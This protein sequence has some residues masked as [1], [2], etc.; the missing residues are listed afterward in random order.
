MVY[1]S[2]VSMMSE[3]HRSYTYIS[4]ANAGKPK[5]TPNEFYFPGVQEIT[6]NMIEIWGKVVR[7]KGINISMDRIYTNIPLAEKLLEMKIT[8]IGTLQHNRRGLPA[9][10]KTVEK[11][12]EQSYKMYYEEKKGKMT[13]HSYFVKTKSKG[14]KNILVQ[15]TTQPLL[16]T[17]KDDGK[18]KPAL[19]KL[20]DFTKGGTDIMDQRIG[21]YSLKTMSRKWSVVNFPYNLDTIR[22]NS[23]TLRA[24]NTGRGPRKVDSLDCGWNLAMAMIELHLEGRKQALGLTKKAKAKVDM[25][26]SIIQQKLTTPRKELLPST[27]EGAGKRCITKKTKDAMGKIKTQCQECGE[28]VC[29]KHFLLFCVKCYNKSGVEESEEEMEDE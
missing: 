24:L 11:R 25:M 28:T 7:L 19:L 5:G 26:L 2:R 20:Y 8:V 6:L 18:V 4:S 16:G 1:C 21:S 27:F 17:T 10:I 14:L 9:E 12:E 3:L 23:Q 29:R 13:L 22:V 15:S